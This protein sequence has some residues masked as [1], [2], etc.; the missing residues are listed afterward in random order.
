MGNLVVWGTQQADALF[1][2][3]QRPYRRGS[4][5]Y[6][7]L[8]KR[9]MLM[10]GDLKRGD[11]WIFGMKSHRYSG[12]FMLNDPPLAAHFTEPK[13]G[14]IWILDWESLSPVRADAKRPPV[15]S[16]DDEEDEIEPKPPLISA[17]DRRRFTR[18]T[19][20][21]KSETAYVSSINKIILHPAYQQ[22]IGMGPSVIELILKDMQQEERYW[23]WALESL[24]GENPVSDESRRDIT[25]LTQDWLEW[26][27]GH[28]YL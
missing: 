20:E 21:W 23:F 12:M 3:I 22:I 26:G 1:G 27:K 10:V 11:P 2:F 7:R 28:G 24:T 25:R 14:K 5:P 4:E 18:L 8:E 9:R 17:E 16:A 13:D 15:A 19:Q 6:A